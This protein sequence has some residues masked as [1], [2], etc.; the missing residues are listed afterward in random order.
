[1]MRETERN[2]RPRK[3][4]REPQPLMLEAGQPSCP[5]P[6]SLGQGQQLQS[7][8]ARTQGSPGDEQRHGER[9]AR[10]CQR[11][12]CANTRT[13]RRRYLACYMLRTVSTVEA[14]AMVRLSSS[15]SLAIPS[16]PGPAPA[17][18]DARRGA[19]VLAQTLHVWANTPDAC[20]RCAT[21]QGDTMFAPASSRE[22]TPRARAEQPRDG[23][24]QEAEEV[25][26]V[27]QCAFWMPKK[28]RHC[29]NQPKP[30]HRCCPGHASPCSR[31]WHSA[32]AC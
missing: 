19:D 20:A 12:T 16:P 13:H 11:F 27:A 28:R 2:P 3:P 23:Q 15:V 17:A 30:G 7:A 8:H 24:P 9:Q 21:P 5:S 26:R 1:M 32:R 18:R 10:H 29:A 6:G 22:P 25:Q 31:L 14:C 4:K